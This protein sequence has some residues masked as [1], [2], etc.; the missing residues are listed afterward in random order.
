MQEEEQLVLMGRVCGSHLNMKN[1]LK[2]YSNVATFQMI[3]R[4]VIERTMLVRMEQF[5]LEPGSEHKGAIKGSLRGKDKQQNSLV[6]M[7][8]LKI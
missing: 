2:Y 4:G 8:Q 5:N 6:I 3:S 1:Y 7:D